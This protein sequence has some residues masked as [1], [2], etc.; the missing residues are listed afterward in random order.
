MTLTVRLR[1]PVLMQV[2]HSRSQRIP[3]VHVSAGKSRTLATSYFFRPLHVWRAEV[4]RVADRR[5]F[6]LVILPGDNDRGPA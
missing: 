3:F 4:N 6:F 5:K 1:K 2:R